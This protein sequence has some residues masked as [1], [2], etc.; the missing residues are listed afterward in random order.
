MIKFFKS[1]NLGLNIFNFTTFNS[2]KKVNNLH[3]NTSINGN[4]KIIDLMSDI[5][6]ISMSNKLLSN[7]QGGFIELVRNCYNNKNIF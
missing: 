6:I 7:S 3:Y 1:N 2:N 4:T 5:Y